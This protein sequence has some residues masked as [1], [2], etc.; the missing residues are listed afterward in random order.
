[1]RQVVIYPGEEGYWVAEC[2]SLSG[3]TSQ[4]ETKLE[5][6]VSIRE[7]IEGYVLALERRTVY[8]CPK[9]GSRRSYWPYDELAKSIRATMLQSAQ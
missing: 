2:P 5:A 3:C 1:M 7:A 4:G 6:I 9:S 8:L